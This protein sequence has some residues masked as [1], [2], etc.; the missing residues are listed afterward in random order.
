M[1][2]AAPKP[3][4]RQVGRYKARC[5]QFIEIVNIRQ[6]GGRTICTGYTC[7]PNSRGHFRRN[8][9][10]WDVSGRVASAGGPTPWDAIGVLQ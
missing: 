4:I 1:K 3:V 5:G 2:A 8:L 9:N 10:T 7:E 6:A